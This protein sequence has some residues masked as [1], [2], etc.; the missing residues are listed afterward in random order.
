MKRKGIRLK[1]LEQPEGHN[2]TNWCARI[3]DIAQYFFPLD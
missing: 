1:Y 2:W 3:D